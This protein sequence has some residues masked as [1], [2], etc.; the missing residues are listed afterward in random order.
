[1]VSGAITQLHANPFAFSGLNLPSDPE[2]VGSDY[3]CDSPATTLA[4]TNFPGKNKASVEK[5]LPTAGVRGWGGGRPLGQSMV[6][7]QGLEFQ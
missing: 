6:R 2:G 5:C 3:S 4:P 7:M 1:M